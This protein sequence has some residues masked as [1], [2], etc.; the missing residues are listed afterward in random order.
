MSGVLRNFFL[1]NSS[2]KAAVIYL[3]NAQPQQLK[4]SEYVAEDFGEFSTPSQP[5]ES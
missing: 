2:E 3:F 1:H 5:L 4:C